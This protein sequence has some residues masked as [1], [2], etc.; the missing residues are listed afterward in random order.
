MQTFKKSERL[1]S[2]K[3][4]DLL[5]KKGKTLF[6]H[7]L[8]VIWLTNDFD[9]NYPSKLFVSVSKKKINKAVDRNKMKRRIK[10]A[11]RKNKAFFYEYLNNYDIK[12]Y[13]AILY[14]SNELCTY[15]KIEKKIISILKRLIEELE[16]KQKPGY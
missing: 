9:S 1:Y 3:C 16:N 10:E 4:I 11:F 5:F 13:L 14:V 6:N 12:C 15:N 2:K 7:P 8:K